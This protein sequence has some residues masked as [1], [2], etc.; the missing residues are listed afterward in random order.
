[1]LKYSLPALVIGFVLDS[2]DRRSQMALSSDLCHRQSDR[3]AGKG[4]PEDFSR[5]ITAVS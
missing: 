5:K 2:S 1:M 4:D 3:S